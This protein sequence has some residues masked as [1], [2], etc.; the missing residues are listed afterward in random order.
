[1]NA[2]PSLELLERLASQDATAIETDRPV[3]THV[4]SCSSCQA[5]LAEVRH[6]DFPD[7]P[8]AKEQGYDVE[9]YMFSKEGRKADA[10]PPVE[11]TAPAPPSG[12]TSAPPAP[13]SN[14]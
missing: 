12:D 3:W 9:F 14:P 10:P 11:E 13:P 2:C 4:D 7:V 1:M 6:P 5:M 8:T